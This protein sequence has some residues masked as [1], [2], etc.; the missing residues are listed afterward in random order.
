MQT[1]LIKCWLEKRLNRGSGQHRKLIIRETWKYE[2]N[3]LLKFMLG[4]GEIIRESLSR[5]NF[6]NTAR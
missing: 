3:L 1:R 2:N 4:K 6:G 5:V